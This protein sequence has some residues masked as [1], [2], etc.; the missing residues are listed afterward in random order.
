MG[1]SPAF[2]I[3]SMELRREWNKFGSVHLTT[4]GMGWILCS[5]K[6]TDTM[7]EVLNGGPW[8][9]GRNIVGMDRWSPSFDPKSFKGITTP[10]WIQFPC[11]PLVCWDEDNNARIASFIGK[12]LF[13]D[14]N[15]FK[16]GKREYAQICVKINLENKLPNNVWADGTL[17]RFF[18]KVEYE[19]IDLLCYHCG[20]V[21]HERITCPDDKTIPKAMQPVK[22]VFK[23]GNDVQVPVEAKDSDVGNSEYGPWIQVK[24]KNNKFRNGRFNGGTKFVN[25]TIKDSLIKNIN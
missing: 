18:Q 25:K 17:G 8:Y 10:V 20:K 13:L 7:E 11:L 6:N 4:L 2:P 3:C 9:V 12:P 19:K 15:S 23:P 22:Q 5:F 1:K 21:G 24:F 14:R 16:C